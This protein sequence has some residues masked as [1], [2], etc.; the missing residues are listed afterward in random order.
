M[1]TNAVS[2]FT[3]LHSVKNRNFLQTS[4]KINIMP[5]AKYIYYAVKRVL[6]NICRE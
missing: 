6:A 1:I 3:A 2:L 4:C 5:I